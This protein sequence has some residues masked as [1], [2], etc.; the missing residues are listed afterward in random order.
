MQISLLLWRYSNPPGCDPVRF[1]L[2]ECA[3]AAGLDQMTSRDPLQAQPACDSVILDLTALA[4]VTDKLR[5]V[6]S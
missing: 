3:L 5:H 4:C 6:I 1:A 2:G